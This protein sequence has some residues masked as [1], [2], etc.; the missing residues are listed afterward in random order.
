M[1]KVNVLGWCR[2]NWGKLVLI[3]LVVFIFDSILKIYD[4]KAQRER[5]NVAFSQI[6]PVRDA[7]NEHVKKT[8]KFPS[9]LSPFLKQA[10]YT[11]A[12]SRFGQIGF[13]VVAEGQ[14]LR[15]VFD[16]DQ[17]RFAD[18]AL[19]LEGT[20]KNG[21]AIWSCTVPGVPDGYVPGGCR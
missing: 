1:Q 19:I 9:D 11:I 13:S 6:V 16:S 7:I 10:R 15:V 5:L 20:E 18:K 12:H 2:R 14:R 8:G 21:S 4:D 3:A 17:G